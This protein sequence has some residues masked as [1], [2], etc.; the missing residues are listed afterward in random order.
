MSRRLKSALSSATKSSMSNIQDTMVECKQ[1]LEELRKEI[2]RIS[3]DKS[4]KLLLPSDVP[5]DKKQTHIKVCLQLNYNEEKEFTIL[6][7]VLLPIDL[8]ETQKIEQSTLRDKINFI[9]K[10][11]KHNLVV[12]MLFRDHPFTETQID[13]LYDHYKNDSLMNYNM[14]KII[15]Y[16]KTLN[17]KDFDETKNNTLSQAIIQSKNGTMYNL[18]Y[19]VSA[20]NKDII[21]KLTSKNTPIYI[22]ISLE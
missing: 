15:N 19:G 21:S 12:G 10:S 13:T 3:I 7:N 22:S 17:I 18:A 6:P 1:K 20:N 14:S 2:E 11:L 8:F 4:I 16:I 9:Q 5:E